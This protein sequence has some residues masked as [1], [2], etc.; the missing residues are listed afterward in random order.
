MTGKL[1]VNAPIF[2]YNYTNTNNA[3]A[4]MFDKPSSNY[5]GI[6]AC[7]QNDM[8]HFGPCSAS[9]EW[10]SSYNQIWRFQGGVY[11]TG[12]LETDNYG[13]GDPGSGTGGYGRGGAIY[14][15][16]IG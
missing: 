7:G 12:W 5:T 15:K 4:F 9:G 2:G 1:Q 14:F 10:V 8:I 13:S 11:A 6:G 3:A 16:V